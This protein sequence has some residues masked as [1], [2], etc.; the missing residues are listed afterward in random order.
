MYEG[1]CDCEQTC[2]GETGCNVELRWEEHRNISKDSEPAKHMKENWS[3]KVSWKILFTAPENKRYR[4]I[5]EASEIALKKPSLK[6]QTESI[7]LL[8]FCYGVTNV[9]RFNCSIHYVCI[10]CHEN[11]Q[12][13]AF[14]CIF[15]D[16]VTL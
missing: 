2:I 5:L 13:K 7:K 15:K 3:H 11:C 9:K 14:K 12:I 10:Y 4:K 8:L 16:T 6:E 1:L